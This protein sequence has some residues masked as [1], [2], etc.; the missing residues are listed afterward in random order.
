MCTGRDVKKHHF[1]GSLFVVADCQ[2]DGIPD[3]AQL[4][5]FR[6]TELDSAGDMAVMDIQTWND[7]FR[8]HTQS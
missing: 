5:R 7:T 6:F 3:I 2:L 4:T 8:N 1:V